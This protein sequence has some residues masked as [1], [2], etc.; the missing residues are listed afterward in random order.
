MDVVILV[1]LLNCLPETCL[2]GAK[3]RKAALQDIIAANTSKLGCAMPNILS[4]NVNIKLI[5]KN[6]LNY[7][8]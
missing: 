8:R 1:I 3:D 6:N 4:N 5:F 2:Q 7:I